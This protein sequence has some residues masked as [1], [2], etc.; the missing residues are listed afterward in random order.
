MFGR[1]HVRKPLVPCPAPVHVR[2]RCTGHLHTIRWAKGHL[3]F[4]SHNLR[5]LRLELALQSH[6]PSR[7]AI[8]L[9][10]LF[11]HPQTGCFPHVPAPL[12]MVLQAWRGHRASCGHGHPPDLH[13]I[14]RDWRNTL[15][16]Q[17]IPRHFRPLVETL[18]A[19]GFNVQISPPHG[20]N[21]PEATAIL[22]AAGGAN[23]GPP[24]GFYRGGRWQLD[25]RLI[26]DLTCIPSEAERSL[27][28]L[29]SASCLPC[30]IPRP[31]DLAGHLTSPAHRA[32]IIAAVREIFGP[33]VLA[34]RDHRSS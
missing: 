25:L 1:G 14:T 3:E 13:Q 12:R 6:T 7:C 4:L 9:E 27:L 28:C 24:I 19:R 22:I 23:A 30:K 20:V 2:V 31:A 10:A 26:L 34:S 33:A 21:L 32:T 18:A 29:S 15:R 17:A 16:T 11:A 8:I 5:D